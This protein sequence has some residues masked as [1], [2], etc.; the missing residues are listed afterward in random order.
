MLVLLINFIYKF[1]IV[2]CV[3]DLILYN[4]IILINLVFFIFNKFLVRYGLEL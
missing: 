1:M 4:C 2:L 3:I